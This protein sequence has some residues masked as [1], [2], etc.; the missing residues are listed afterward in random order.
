ML[1]FIK[2]NME[3]IHDVQIFP[4]IAFL[5]FFTFFVGLLFYVFT[6]NK[7]YIDQVSQLPL[8]EDDDPAFNINQKEK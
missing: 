4:I 1:K 5:I 3:N 6:K 2:G 7:D 8:E